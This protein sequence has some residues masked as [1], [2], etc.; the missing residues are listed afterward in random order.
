MMIKPVSPH[1]IKFKATCMGGSCSSLVLSH[2]KTSI[3]RAFLGAVPVSGPGT[4]VINFG[5]GT[6]PILLDDLMCSGDEDNLL[7]CEQMSNCNHGEDAGVTCRR[8]GKNIDPHS[9]YLCGM[10]L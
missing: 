10:Q 1:S 2:E 7:L 8:D 4:S 5:Q 9:Y 3:L 6:G